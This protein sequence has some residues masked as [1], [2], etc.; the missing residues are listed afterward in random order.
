MAQQAEISLNYSPL[1]INPG[2]SLTFSFTQETPFILSSGL[3]QTIRPEKRSTE[4][5][6]EGKEKE[7]Q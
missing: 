4:N 6:T 1:I 2:K 7:S 3:Q 5:Q